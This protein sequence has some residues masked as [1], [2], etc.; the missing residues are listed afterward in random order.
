MWHAY[1]SSNIFHK[2]LNSE[3]LITRCSCYEYDTILVCLLLLDSKKEKIP[4]LFAP[5]AAT[6]IYLF[7]D[8]KA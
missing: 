7:I 3:L 5:E 6:I 4:C 2:H 1:N 8:P